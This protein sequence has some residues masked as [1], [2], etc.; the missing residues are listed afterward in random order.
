MPTNRNKNRQTIEQNIIE[1]KQHNKINIEEANYLKHLKRN[2]NFPKILQDGD[3][4]EHCK[5][6]IRKDRKTHKIWTE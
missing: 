4:N 3:L 6:N 1:K 5:T 2:L